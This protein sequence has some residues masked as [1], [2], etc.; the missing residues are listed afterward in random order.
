MNPTVTDLASALFDVSRDALLLASCSDG[1]IVDAN[2]AAAELFGLS[3]DQLRLMRI[4]EIL[5]ADSDTIS[6]PDEA[7]YEAEPS[8]RMLT[9]DR[10]PGL[11]VHVQR[12]PVDLDGTSRELFVVRRRDITRNEQ[13]LDGQTKIL[14]QLA[15]GTSLETILT[16]IVLLIEDVFEETQ[17]SV[18]LLSED[19]QRLLNG[20]APS[21]PVAYNQA[22]DGLAIGEGVGSCGTAA[23]RQQR[24]IVKDIQADSLWEPYRE[25]AAGFDLGACWSQPVFSSSGAV[26]GTFAMYY[27]EPNEPSTEELDLIDHAARLAG[28]AIERWRTETELRRQRCELE[29]ILDAV[30]AQVVYMDTS[31][32]A[33]RH[34]RVSRELLGLGDE[35][36]RGN[37]VIEQ[38]PEL[39]NP[40]LRHE[41][42]IEVIRTGIPQLGSIEKFTGGGGP[43]NSGE[44][45]VSID[46]VPTFD[47]EGNVDGLLLFSYDITHLKET[48]DALRESEERFR[49]LAEHIDSAFWMFD[50]KLDRMLYIS[51]TYERVFGRPPELMYGNAEEFMESVLPED[52]ELVLE[53]IKRQQAGLSTEVEY[54]ITRPGGEVRWIRDRAFPIRNEAGELIRIAGI[55]DDITH[56]K[57]TEEKLQQHHNELAHASRLT[58]MGELAAGLA[59]E[60]NQPLAAIANFSVVGEEM[61]NRG[62]PPDMKRLCEVMAM[63][64]SQSIRAANILKRVSQF[65]SR[66]PPRRAILNLNQIVEDAAR[67]L[68]VDFRNSQVRLVLQLD[69]SLPDVAADS[70]QL[71]QVLVNLARN[72]L[73]AILRNATEEPNRI[74]MVVTHRIGDLVEAAVLDRGPGLGED[75]DRI[76]DAFFTTREDGMGLG[77]R[78]SQSIAEA[79]KGRLFAANRT[80][81][82]AVFRLQLPIAKDSSPA[83]VTNKQ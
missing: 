7:R 22:I 73:E 43:D 63:L 32:R 31:A 48:E 1:A 42:S 59:H 65:A 75:I 18:L 21:L 16:S 8:T 28:V 26:L 3:C 9:R 50:Y 47:D 77:L 81:G 11:A 13:F 40:A 52:R 58:T 61:V 69:D 5:E 80:E 64:R 29:V 4:G 78:I 41:Q 6:S 79:H 57:T 68:E 17:A 60:L 20:A 72:S 44:R 19:G 25:L 10:Q 30:H 36:I 27:A 70:V 53:K 12:L 49:Q 14:E 45:W 67:L 82:G 34:N 38:T 33:V 54:R 62:V 15:Y 76:F 39:D 51:P 83:I 35:G 37:T 71:Q 46:K 24:V 23:F 56:I 74:V 55:G 2:P 66:T